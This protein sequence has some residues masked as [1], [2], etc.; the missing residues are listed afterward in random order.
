MRFIAKE[1]AGASVLA[2]ILTVPAQADD[3]DAPPGWGAPMTE[4]YF[5]TF[6]V[7]RLE[8]DW[9][10]ENE[11]AVVWDFQGWYGGDIQ[12]VYIKGEGANVQG[13]DEDAEFESLDLLYS[14]LIADFWELQGGVGYQGGIASND[15]PERGFAVLSLFGQLPYRFE[16]DASLRVSDEGDVSADLEAEYDLR[17]TQRIYLQPR[18]EITAAAQEVPEFGVGEGLNSARLG[19]RLRYEISRKFAPYIGGYWQKQYGDTADMSRE[20]GN[21]PEGTGVVAGVR[22]WF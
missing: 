14:H 3:Y 17:L 12:R 8:Y 11:E 1:L 20:L 21:E 5:G 19:L 9:T 18:T 2:M 22:M 10:D 4:H 7:D 15:H 13:D 16:V 6:L